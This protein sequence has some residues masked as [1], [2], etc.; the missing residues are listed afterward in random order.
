MKK[1]TAF[2]LIGILAIPFILTTMSVQARLDGLAI[3]DTF[4]YTVS[5]FDYPSYNFIYDNPEE[6]P[7][8]P[9]DY[10]IDLTG[11]MIGMKIMDIGINGYYGANEYIVLDKA[12]QI[13][14]PYYP[15]A[16]GS[17]N[18]LYDMFGDT[19]T[20]PS[21]VGIGLGVTATLSDLLY[22]INNPDDYNDY[23]YSL[24]GIGIAM[25]VLYLDPGSWD[26]Y[27]TY[28]R[29]SG[30]NYTSSQSSTTT[31]IDVTRTSSEFI[32]S[33]TMEHQYTWDDP[34]YGYTD[35]TTSEYRLS[36]YIT[37]SNAGILYKQYSLID[38]QTTYTGT[39]YSD[40]PDRHIHQGIEIKFESKE[41]LPLPLEVRAYEDIS[42]KIED[43]S[44]DVW[45]NGF[46]DVEAIND[47]IASF[48][49]DFTGA[50]GKEVLKFEIE[51]I[52]GCYYET[53]I[54]TYDGSTQSLVEQPGTI[55]WNGF[56]GFPT[57][58]DNWYYG[59]D[60]PPLD[61]WGGT[62]AIVPFSPAITPDYDMWR[63]TTKSMD[64]IFQV[65]KTAVTSM[66]G[67]EFLTENGFIVGNFDLSSE[68]RTTGSYKYIYLY[69]GFD[70]S[71]DSN[72]VESSKRS[73]SW[74]PDQSFS[75]Y[76]NLDTW[77]SYTFQGL[78]AGVGIDI[79]FDLGF[80]NFQVDE[81]WD[82]GKYEWVPVYDNGYL[83]L[84]LS[85][86]LQNTKFS[87]IPEASEAD[88]DLGNGDGGLIPSFTLVTA[89]L[90]L[91][92]SSAI[93]RRKRR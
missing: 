49:D 78:I 22:T 10:I 60:E 74:I 93:L 8:D 25:S 17:E 52:Q 5:D 59:G 26:T 61:Y 76:L 68:L 66:P 88:P 62:L 29:E 4:K 71:F 14:I 65:I 77:I 6:M 11:S 30:E 48:T 70:I 41:N 56:S 81:E 43:A 53:T 13:P 63:G 47:G 85:V 28:F 38:S 90:V 57:Y 55:W 84:N 18:L 92:S 89:I 45:T 82:E 12:I 44:V 35:T 79:N 21:G 9:N 20:V 27:E 80:T 39:D 54:H 91:A 69:G 83:D 40:L 31:Y 42:L 3:G 33:V 64:A 86:K 16:I 1:K 24:Y 73:S 87:N 46:F 2:I 32:V 19:V 34:Q 51:S 58:K 23:Y 7:Y 37:G 15:E 75:F 36:W 50:I 67:E 72:L